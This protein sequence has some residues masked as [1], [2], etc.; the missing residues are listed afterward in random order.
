MTGFLSDFSLVYPYPPA[1]SRNFL[2]TDFITFPELSSPAQTLYEHMTN[3]IKDHGMKVIAMTPTVDADIESEYC[4]VRTTEYALTQYKEFKVP[5]RQ[6][7]VTDDFDIGLVITNMSQSNVYQ[8]DAER[9]TLKLQYFIVL[10][11][12]RD[13]FPV[14]YLEKKL[15]QFKT[16]PQTPEVIPRISNNPVPVKQHIGVRKQSRRPYKRTNQHQETAENIL[17]QESTMAREKMNELI[18]QSTA[19]CRKDSLW[20]RMLIVTHADE[21]VKKKKRSDTEES[22]DGFQKLSHD[23]FLELLGMVVKQKLSDIDP[24]LMP[25]H[26]MSFMWYKSLYKVLQSRYPETHRSFSS[27][28]GHVQYL[29]VVNPQFPDMLM[30]LMIDVKD[31]KTDL[32]AVFREALSDES[33]QSKPSLPFINIQDHET[34]FIN[35]CCFHLWASLL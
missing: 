8:T 21:D 20:N 32:C 25:F 33:D 31:H 34:D 5:T 18:R 2:L 3:H 26:N 19:E 15:G 12:K 6:K 30:M 24:Q 29:V 13:L 16:L 9:Y 27:P 14:A 4:F 28:D 35:V 22:K 10:T 7:S 11:S 17:M 1:F 23:E